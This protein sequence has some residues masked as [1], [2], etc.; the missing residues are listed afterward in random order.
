MAGSQLVLTRYLS[1][2]Y[3]YLKFGIQHGKFTFTFPSLNEEVG[4]RSPVP[5]TI[6][7]PSGS[8]LAESIALKNYVTCDG[9]RLESNRFAVPFLRQFLTFVLSQYDQVPSQELANHMM[10]FANG[11]R[12][13][14]DRY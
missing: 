13:G 4:V 3:L 9:I 14:L 1:D 8:P 5:A 10:R 11:G 12:T 6:G 7:I 2:L